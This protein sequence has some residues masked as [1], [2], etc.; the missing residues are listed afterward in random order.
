M[1]QILSFFL[2]GTLFCAS[3]PLANAMEEHQEA[4]PIMEQK[5]LTSGTCG[6]AAYWHYAP[7]SATITI[8]GT[9]AMD[10]YP[11]YAPPW[12]QYREEI[13]TLIIEEG[14]TTV[15]WSAFQWCPS[16]E[17]VSLPNTIE[18]LEYAAFSFCTSLKEIY[19]PESLRCIGI[20]AFANSTQLS[21]LTVPQGT[22]HIEDSAF[23]D[24]TG[25]TTLILPSSVTYIGASAFKN[26]SSLSRVYFQGSSRYGMSINSFYNTN[27]TQATWV[28]QNYTPAQAPTLPTP[29]AEPTY[30]AWAEDFISFV[31]PQIM[32]DITVYNHGETINRGQIAQSLYN[33][34]GEVG[35][36]SS[37][38][39][40]SD[41]GDYS[42]AI[43]W[44]HGN[45]LMNGQSDSY[46]ATEQP[47][48]R[49]QFAL[50]LQKTADFLGK[51]TGDGTIFAISPYEDVDDISPW[52][53]SAVMWAVFY[54]LME[55]NN[56]KLNPSGNVTRTEV[57]VMLYQFHR[58]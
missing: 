55:G 41:Q 48:T 14:I 25:L 45:G 47:L 31:S 43:A 21:S 16:L 23:L 24:C 20:A 36:M 46:F 18:S 27:F 4:S 53:Q 13:Q 1:K 12:V 7:D 52:A 8:S 51:P 37:S 33:M 40:F 17:N 3:L 58:L 34:Y 42:K 49:E 39:V 2:A 56:G 28:Y 10:D 15:G 30:P 9:G 5:T 50:I 35:G 44:C 32:P 57:A 19:L 29:E 54:R 6:A 22:T 26:C 11:N 38:H